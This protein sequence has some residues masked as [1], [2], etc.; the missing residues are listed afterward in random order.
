METNT[1]NENSNGPADRPIWQDLWDTRPTRLPRDQH[2][3]TWIMGVAEGIAMRY[4]VSVTLIRL[5]FVALSLVAGAGIITYLLLVLVLP[6]YGV[7][8]AP[9]ESLWKHTSDSRLRHDRSVGVASVILGIFLS[10]GSAQ[11]DIQWLLV[12]W[13]VVGLVF[14]ML[15]QRLPQPVNSAFAAATVYAPETP[16]TPA[17]QQPEPPRQEPPAWDPLGA[18]PF[19]WDLPDPEPVEPT[20]AAR[21][22]KKPRKKAVFWIGAFLFIDLIIAL[23]IGLFVMNG[24][25]DKRTT[26]M[27]SGVT[28][29]QPADLQHGMSF[30]ASSSTVAIPKEMKVDRQAELTVEAYA[31]SLELD[32]PA[33]TDGNTYRVTVECD[34]SVWTS[35]DAPQSRVVPG[36]DYDK[37][38]S[39][40]QRAEDNVDIPELRI[41]MN[42]VASSIS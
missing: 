13:A 31:S 16:E 37:L 22:A 19:A 36:Q 6:R 42:G 12:T 7:P 3:G 11:A 1:Y 18:A 23:I 9:L 14:W 40:G 15:Y 39:Q 5:L 20:G 27:S 28:Q 4:Q 35:C 38:T 24:S 32:V 34:L 8:I 25:G 21:K 30:I 10:A 26:S 29:V 2:Q 41:T 33:H 17:P